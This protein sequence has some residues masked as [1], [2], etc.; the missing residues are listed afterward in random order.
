MKKFLIVLKI[1]KK[2]SRSF[3]TTTLSEIAEERDPFK[4]LIS[5]L[6]SL[7]TR[8]ETTER[9]SKK[10]YEL[11]NNS[12]DMAKLN[13]KEIAKTIKSVNYYK[14]KA[15]RIKAISKLSLVPTGHRKPFLP[16][17]TAWCLVLNGV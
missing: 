14:T 16:W 2:N 7:R 3:A 8:D 1:L 15:K 6:L 10:L 13:E 17:K 4:V 5:C 12:K 9:V 11:A